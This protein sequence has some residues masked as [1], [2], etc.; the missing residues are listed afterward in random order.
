MAPTPNA[1]PTARFTGYCDALACSLGGSSSSDPEGALTRYAWDLGDGTTATGAVV[2]HRYATAGERDVTLTVTDAAGATAS[3]TR[4]AVAEDA[5]YPAV[6]GFSRTLVD[7]WGSAEVGGT[8]T[9]DGSRSAFDVTGTQGT[10]TLVKG[11][12]RGAHLSA[13]SVQDV[14]A[15]AQVAINRRRRALAPISP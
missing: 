13:A 12:S 14:D 9:L 2:Q 3:T 15:S 5:V 7:N 1:P 8:Y 10:V 6:D 11:A 4:R